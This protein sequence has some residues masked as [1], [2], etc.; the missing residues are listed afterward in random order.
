MYYA[1]FQ[2]KHGYEL[3]KRV[4]N[5]LMVNFC[6]EHPGICHCLKLACSKKNKQ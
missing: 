3:T 6:Q 5:K 4:T 1:A 2:K